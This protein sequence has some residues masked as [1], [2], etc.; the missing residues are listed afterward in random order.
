MTPLLLAFAGILFGRRP[1]A[2]VYGALALATLVA[3]LGTRG[4]LF[5]LLYQWLPGFRIVYLPARLGVLAAFALACLAGLGADRVIGGSWSLRRATAVAAAAAL[6]PLVILAQF[7]HA[8]GYDQFRYLLTNLGRFTGGPFL[9]REQEAQ[10]ALMAL[11]TLAALALAGRRPGARAAWAGWA[12]AGLTAVDLGLA[13]WQ[14]A[15]RSFSPDDWYRPAFETAAALGPALGDG[16]YAGLQWHGAQH[17]LN[18]FPR[19]ASPALL[20]PNLGTLVGLRDAQ[21]YNPLLLRRAADYFA[22]LTH[23][24][25]DDHWLWI[26][27]FHH[28]FTDRLSVRHVLVQ[29]ATSMTLRGGSKRE[30]DAQPATISATG[31]GREPQAATGPSPVPEPPAALGVAVGAAWRVAE[32]RLAPGGVKALRLPPDGSEQ[33]VWRGAPLRLERLRVVSYLGEATLLPQGTPGIQLRLLDQA[34]AETALT[35]RAGIETAEWAYGRPDVRASV[36]HQQAPVGLETR[37]QGA[38][39]GAYRVFEYM[40]VLAPPQP[41]EATEI[42]AQSLVPGVTAFIRGVWL[43]PGPERAVRP[44]AGGTALE[45]AAARPRV[46]VD[47]GTATI[48]RDESGRIEIVAA[49]ATG[50]NVSLAD[51]Y[52]PGWVATVDGQPAPISAELG[53]FRSVPVPAGRHLVVFEYRPQSLRLGLALTAGGLLLAVAVL[54]L[55]LRPRRRGTKLALPHAAQACKTVTFPTAEV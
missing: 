3:A 51:T 24:P 21:A 12:L 40:A 18:D 14:A 4:P 35:L 16:R 45:L 7:W 11:A 33:V 43:A 17:F 26:D 23:E 53:L 47:G 5:P 42:R 2:W 20:P 10:Y 55:D 41:V 37:L 9:T 25:D 30:M 50:G 46:S 27:D 8:E 49:T 1:A 29:D 32:W 22:P 13:Q 39:A 48:V 15:P 44:A 52:Y 38:V 36:R 19:S 54:A 6:A 28:P 34:G 31:A